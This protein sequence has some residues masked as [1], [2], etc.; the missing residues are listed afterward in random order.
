MAL[1]HLAIIMDGNRRWAKKRNLPLAAG[2]AAGLDAL[3][4]TVRL[5]ANRGIK[6][7]T[8]FS[9]S[10]ENLLRPKAELE[11]LF[12]LIAEACRQYTGPMRQD[13]VR[14]QTIGDLNR[15]PQPV[16]EALA[17]AKEA[18]SSCDTIDLVLALGYGGR[19]EIMRA[20]A[21]SKGDPTAIEQHLDTSAWPDPDMLIRTSGERRLSN[22]LLWQMA[23]TELHFTDAMWPDFNEEELDRALENYNQRERRKGL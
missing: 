21:K 14:L 16:Q 23:Y 3:H 6:T 9:L 2:H 22:F 4:K 7:L 18:T 19:D 20:V 11:G 15:L 10:T 1:E 8:A 5:A 13:G 17:E 12:I